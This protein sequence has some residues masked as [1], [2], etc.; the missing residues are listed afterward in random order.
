MLLL[1]LD[2]Y[3]SYR[4]NYLQLNTI[5]L[6]SYVYLFKLLIFKKYLNIFLKLIIF[7]D[8]YVLT[9]MYTFIIMPIKYTVT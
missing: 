7:L 3:S 2:K 1:V 5:F 4:L 8:Y 9:K 6:M